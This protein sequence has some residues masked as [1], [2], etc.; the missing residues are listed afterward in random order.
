MTGNGRRAAPGRILTT[1][2]GSLPRPRSLVELYVARTAGGEIDPDALDREG[3]AATRWVVERQRASGIDIPSDGEQ[4]R[5]AF[6]LYV[7]R[8]MSGFGG[9][10]ERGGGSELAAYPEFAEVRRAFMRDRLAVSNMDPPMAIGP[11]RHV[12]PEAN[13]AEI[14]LFRDAL[15]RHDGAFVDAFMT[16]PSPGIVAT[17]I[18]NAHY[19]DQD[20]YLDALAEALSVEY[21]AAVEAGFILQ[22]DAPDLG[23]E[24][25]MLFHDRPLPEFIDFV[26]GV[27]A[28]INAM[29]AGLPRERVRLHVCYGNYESPH[30]RDVPL[31]DI[32]PSL[33]RANV[34]GFLFPFANPRHAHEIRLFRSMPL[35]PDQY[36]IVGAIDTLTAFVEH[37]EVVADRLERAAEAVGDPSRIM[38]GTDCGFDTSAGMGRLTSDVVWAKLRALRDGADLASRRLF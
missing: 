35:D 1:H 20:A 22:I 16:A 26:D 5:E 13:A 9:R 14:A 3:E 18:R 31:E 17:A 15:S 28:R 8:R 33:L 7:Q 21:R 6:F 25:H 10:W 32:L 36:L 24:R 38:A 19:P 30:D 27:I 23:L 11:V 29:I 2:A 4:V 34:G 12:A 37:P